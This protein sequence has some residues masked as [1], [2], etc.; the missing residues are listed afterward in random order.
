M[1]AVLHNINGENKNTHTYINIY[2]S[3]TQHNSKTSF[4]FKKMQPT[5]YCLLWITTPNP[6]AC[7]SPSLPAG[8]ND[9]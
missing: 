3:Y 1:Y 2:T 6:S 9:A 5:F 8:P 7:Q 4:Q